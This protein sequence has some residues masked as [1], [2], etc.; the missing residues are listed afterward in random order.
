MTKRP[1]KVLRM[2]RTKSGTLPVFEVSC[3]ECGELIERSY[4]AVK[5]AE[6]KGIGCI[7][8]RC[9]PKGKRPPTQEKLDPYLERIIE[10]LVDGTCLDQ[11]HRAMRDALEPVC[12]EDVGLYQPQVG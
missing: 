8:D 6:K 7:C 5:S 2:K 3:R 11:V 10:R 1:H 12:V 9:L 4:Q